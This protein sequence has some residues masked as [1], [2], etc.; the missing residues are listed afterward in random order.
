[1]CCIL[2]C[3]YLQSI[4]NLSANG[5]LCRDRIDT[6]HLFIFFNQLRFVWQAG[7]LGNA[8]ACSFPRHT[9][10][11]GLPSP[12]CSFSPEIPHFFPNMRVMRPMLL[13]MPHS[14]KKRKMLS[15]AAASVMIVIRASTSIIVGFN[16]VLLKNIWSCIPLLGHVLYPLSMIK[17]AFLY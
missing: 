5:Y 4:C 11:V 16:W 6:A 9:L 2:P 10:S 15:T 14:L 1:M 3:F 12:S 17:H 8:P 7:T 13:H